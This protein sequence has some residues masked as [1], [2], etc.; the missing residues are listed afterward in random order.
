MNFY[1]LMIMLHGIIGECQAI[2]HR[3]L[4]TSPCMIHQIIFHQSYTRYTVMCQFYAFIDTYVQ[5]ILVELGT[6]T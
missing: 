4:A 1:Y 2:K 6:V 5:I 3:F